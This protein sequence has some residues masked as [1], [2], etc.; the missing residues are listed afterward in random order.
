MERKIVYDKSVKYREAEAA[1]QPPC[2]GILRRDESS[3]LDLRGAG[4]VIVPRLSNAL[5]YALVLW[6]ALHAVGLNW[7][8]VL[9]HWGL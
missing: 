2:L 8:A 6:V 5:M 4:P 3:D 7:G 9:R 1:V